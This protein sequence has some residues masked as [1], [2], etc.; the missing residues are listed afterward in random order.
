MNH[1]YF[2]IYNKNK[3]LYLFRIFSLQEVDE[4]LKPKLIEQNKM[5][6]FTF[7]MFEIYG[8]YRVGLSFLLKN[9]IKYSII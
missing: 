5:R 1:L 2:I 6:D 7:D 9:K 8:L 4:K 3:K